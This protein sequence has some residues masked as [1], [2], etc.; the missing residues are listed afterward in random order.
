M[1]KEEKPMIG[2]YPQYNLLTVTLK[3][4]MIDFDSEITGIKEQE[5]TETGKFGSGMP[6]GR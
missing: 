5:K 1:K 6:S 4:D 2:R 3:I